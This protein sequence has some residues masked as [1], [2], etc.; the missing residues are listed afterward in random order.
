MTGRLTMQVQ[1]ATRC[2]EAHAG[3]FVSRFTMKIGLFFQERV[4][5]GREE[6][7]KRSARS[8][9]FGADDRSFP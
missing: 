9:H 6:I 2:F 3:Q 1:N 5:T 8:S 4:K 7:L